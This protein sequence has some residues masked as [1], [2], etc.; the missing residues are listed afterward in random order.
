MAKLEV[1]LTASKKIIIN[2]EQS[3]TTDK[4]IVERLIILPGDKKV[5]AR[6]DGLPSVMVVEGD[7]YDNVQLFIDTFVNKATAKIKND[8]D[9][10]TLKY[11]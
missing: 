7:A 2:A 4:L 6:I 8:A 5:I 10:G 9:A 11:T 3:V 1:S